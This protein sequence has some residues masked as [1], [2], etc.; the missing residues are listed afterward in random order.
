M[1]AHK[2][3][4]EDFGRTPPCVEIA[5]NVCLEPTYHGG[6]PDVTDSRTGEIA[7][8]PV[9]HLAG[10]IL[11]HDRDGFDVRCQ[12]AVSVDEHFPERARWSI[13]GSLEAGNLTLAPSILCRTGAIGTDGV[14]CGFHGY[15]QNGQWVP[16]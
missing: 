8:G 4:E 16:A 2:H 1:T 5:P 15:V 6:D 13:A 9:E 11:A 14:D 12:G 3:W 7:G 10:F